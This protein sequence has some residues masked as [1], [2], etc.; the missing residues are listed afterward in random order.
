MSSPAG[1][2]TNTWNVTIIARKWYCLSLLQRT[3]RSHLPLFS[4]ANTCFLS[5]SVLIDD[6][7]SLRESWEQAGGIFVHHIDADTTIQ[8]LRDHGIL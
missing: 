6:R 4:K 1:P 5:C 3:T 2:T 8:K 7:D